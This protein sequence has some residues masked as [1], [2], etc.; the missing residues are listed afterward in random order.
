VDAYTSVE[1]ILLVEAC[2]NMRDTCTSCFCLLT[3]VLFNI[4]NRVYDIKHNVMNYNM[5]PISENILLCLFIISKNITNMF[6]LI[7]C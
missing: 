3:D 4:L 1:W 7:M 6:C 2:A 5:D